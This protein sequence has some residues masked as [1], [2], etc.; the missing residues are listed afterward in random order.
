MALTK[1]TALMNLGASIDLVDGAAFD[2]NE[3]TLNLDSLSREVFIVTD[4]QTECT[5]LGFDAAPGG[6]EWVIANCTKTQ[7]TGTIS[8]ADPHCIG[9]LSQ[10]TIQGGA[11]N[12]GAGA[13]I[14]SST[15][16]E[17][18]TG[19]GKDHIAVIATPNWFVGGMYATTTGGGP[20]ITVAVRITGF[21][22]VADLATYSALIAEEN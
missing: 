12:V 15:P 21:R 14:H 10:T 13:H 19:L 17:G 1:K 9:R 3:I 4:I 6:T 2:S 11:A 18:S 20:N 7:Q 8:V 22:C 5:S 16:D